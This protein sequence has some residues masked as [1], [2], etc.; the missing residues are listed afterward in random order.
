[1]LRDLSDG[2]GRRAPGRKPSNYMSWRPRSSLVSGR[3]ASRA[4]KRLGSPAECSLT[5][6]QHFT[7]KRSAWWSVSTK[8]RVARAKPPHPR[9]QARNG[10]RSRRI[11]DRG[12]VAPR[13]RG[14][15]PVPRIPR[16]RAADTRNGNALLRS[17]PRAVPTG[18]HVGATARRAQCLIG[19]C[20]ALWVVFH[21]QHVR[22][23]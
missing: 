12:A 10:P 23:T 16:S 15:G 7:V 6:P 19:L 13:R 20:C 3:H 1:M 14:P 21:E 11:W 22:F 18:C 5:L 17:N 2:D 9:P 8:S 4:V